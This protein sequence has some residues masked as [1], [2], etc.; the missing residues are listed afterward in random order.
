[1]VSTS[2]SF[3]YTKYRSC[4]KLINTVPVLSVG[5]LVIYVMLNRW[6][7][8][9]YLTNLRIIVTQH[10]MRLLVGSKPSYEPE[11]TISEIIFATMVYLDS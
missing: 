1:M 7:V 2:F 10:I 3:A 6:A 4:M 11:S 5:G 9:P 8:K